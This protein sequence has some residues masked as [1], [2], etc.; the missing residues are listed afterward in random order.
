MINYENI[1]NLPTQLP[2]ENDNHYA[3]FQEFLFQGFNRKLSAFSEHVNCSQRTIYAYAKKFNWLERA[4]QY[5]NQKIEQEITQA[6]INKKIIDLQTLELLNKV[7]QRANDILSRNTYEINE[8]PLF[9]QF[10]NID[11]DDSEEEFDKKQIRNFRELKMIE[12]YIRIC[13]NI[14]KQ[15]NK[16]KTN[17]YDIHFQTDEK[18]IE[19]TQYFQQEL[20]VLEECANLPPENNTINELTKIDKLCTE[21]E[22]NKVKTILTDEISTIKAII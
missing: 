12:A 3:I 13:A 10:R 5:D 21:I 17:N 9:Y 8:M 6:Q 19:L 4:R 7:Q 15:Y 2:F 20:Q 1:V 16:I 11:L 14:Q 18:I 22:Q